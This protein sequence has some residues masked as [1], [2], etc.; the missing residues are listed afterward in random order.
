[1]KIDRQRGS[2]IVVTLLM[3]LFLQLVTVAVVTS[4]NISSHVL[5]N[6]ESA[7]AV[8]KTADNLIN[9]LV[10]NKDYF[11]N[12]AKYLDKYGE[13]IIPIPIDLVVVPAIPKILSFKCLRDSLTVVDTHNSKLC[14]VNSK[15]WQL[16]VE[17]NCEQTGASTVVVQGLKLTVLSLENH[18]EKAIAISNMPANIRIQGVWW[19]AK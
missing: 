12:Y 9:Y 2:I 4:A 16:I 13:F 17:V 19:Y 11:V 6:F 1:M 18:A 3:L 14:D 8:E 10:G 15:Y 7:L 5:R